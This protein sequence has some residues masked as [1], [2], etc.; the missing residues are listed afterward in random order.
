MQI[1]AENCQLW[2]FPN[3]VGCLD[4][5]HIQLIS[6]AGSGSHFYNYKLTNSIVLLALVSAK[7]KFI[8]V[9][10]GTNG[11]ASD[12]GV[13]N[14]CSLFKAVINNNLAL[15]NPRPLPGRHSSNVTPF[16]MLADDAFPLKTFLMKPYSGRHLSEDQ[17]IFNYRLSRCRRVVEN[18]F[19]ILAA[20]FRLY[21]MPIYLNPDKVTD[22]VQCTTILHNYLLTR[23]SNHND[24][25]YNTPGSFDSENAETHELIPGEWRHNDQPVVSFLSLPAVRQRNPTVLAKEIRDDFC[26]YFNTN[27]AVPWQWDSVL[28]H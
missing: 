14:A 9:D 3:C 28:G 12:G 26:D 7:Y 21:H 2:N 13:F 18:T 16:V 8:Y 1:S 22:I 15:P 19:G 27:G 23:N 11:R 10:I 17:L 5:K 24:N 20:R 6:P 4:G 25:V